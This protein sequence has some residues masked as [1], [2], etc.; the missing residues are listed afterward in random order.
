MFRLLNEFQRGFPLVPRPFD[1]IGRELGLTEDAVLGEYRLGA[2]QGTISRIGVVFAPNA[3]GASTLA[4]MEVPQAELERIAAIVSA[5]PGVNHNY[6][7]EH[8]LNL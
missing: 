8:R 4:A 5:Q 6:E 2:Q 7:R 1:A 3:V